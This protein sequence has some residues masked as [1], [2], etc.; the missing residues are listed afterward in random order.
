MIL[1]PTYSSFIYRSG[2]R[3]VRKQGNW[4]GMYRAACRLA[5][6]LSLYLGM[7]AGAQ[8][9]WLQRTES[10]MGTRVHVE[11]WQTDSAAGEAAMQA[12]IDEMRRIDA[13]WSPFKAQSELSRVNREAAQQPV[14]VSDELIEL[15]TRAAEMSQ[16][17]EGA[18]DI[19]Y[20]SVGYLYDYRQHKHPDAATIDALLPAIDYRHVQVDAA[21]NTVRFERSGVKIDLGGIAKGYAVDRCIA[22]L[23]ARGIRQATV[24]AGGDSRII[25]SR[26]TADGQARPWMVGVRDPRRE[27]E[28]AV[29]LPLVD[30]AISTSGDYER[31]FEQGG[32]RFHHIIDP[33]TGSSANGVRSVTILGPDATHTDALSTSVFVLGV[34]KGMALID[35][36]AGYEAIIVDARGSLVYSKGLAPPAEKESPAAKKGT[37]PTATTLH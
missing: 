30:T 24:S 14:A 6:A 1:P 20:A 13:L 12:V 26:S 3:C 23:Q 17:S 15:L 35:R 22:I 2:I 29:V 31:Y 25:G 7:A 33:D 5:C 16:L 37:P 28:F 19:T 27:G 18:F 32:Q 11:L 34:D 10:I 8:A 36:M 21:A 4:N 9:D